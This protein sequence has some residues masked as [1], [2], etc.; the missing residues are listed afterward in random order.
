MLDV[1]LEIRRGD[2]PGL[3][4]GSQGSVAIVDL[5]N[6]GREMSYE[7][8]AAQSAYLASV[9]RSDERKLACIVC[10]CDADAIAWYR[11]ILEAGHAVSLRP[12]NPPDS[13]ASFIA[14]YQPDLLVCKS[15][16]AEPLCR[17][18]RLL[19]RERSY[20]LHERNLRGDGVHADLAALFLTSGSMGQPNGVR[21]SFRAVAANARQVASSLR[22]APGERWSVSLPLCFVYGLSV[23]NSAL[24]A[25]AT[26]VIPSR[27]SLDGKFWRECGD[28]KVSCVPA[29]PTMLDWL[30]RSACAAEIPGKFRKVT[31]SGAAMSA[32]LKR[33]LRDGGLGRRC[34]IYSM[35]GMTETS[36]RISVLPPEDFDAHP[37]SVGCAVPGG[38]LSSLASGEIVYS[39][40]NVMMGYARGRVDLGLG[41]LLGGVMHT[42]DLGVLDG[43]GRVTLNGRISRICKIHGR[44]VC[45]DALEHFL[46]EL[47]E[48]AAVSDDEFIDVFHACESQGTISAALRRVADRL[49]LP[50]GVIRSRPLTSIPRTVSGKVCYAELVRWRNHEGR[51]SGLNL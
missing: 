20:L 12:P 27:Q 47:G 35:Y 7:E 13:L 48:I 17:E 50:Y 49:D 46:T 8:L 1:S 14:S 23:V 45:L 19:R 3:H 29:I 15:P 44:K 43:E 21:L 37:D 36:G 9:V 32:A 24:L 38:R 39:G 10:D 5:K 25:G 11:G 28:A 34:A 41:D 4:P 18:Y 30:R 16:L 31:I 51:R 22:M 6:D 2:F 42:G 33:W 40:E 26:L